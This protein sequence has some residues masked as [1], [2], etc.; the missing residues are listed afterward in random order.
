MQDKI[1]QQVESF[2]AFMD[3]ANFLKKQKC[4]A[5][6]AQDF[7]K[8]I[9]FTPKELE[10]YEPA[11]IE[12]YRP[13]RK[14]IDLFNG[15]AKGWELDGVRGT[16]WGLLNSITEYLDHHSPARS[17]D[18]RLNSAWFGGGDAIKNKAVEL[19]AA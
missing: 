6:A 8:Q 1:A 9:L 3:M 16:R 11:S 5:A 18:A 7:M 15:E 14:I 2:G 19:L 4:G 13:Y 12:K 17:D 10:T